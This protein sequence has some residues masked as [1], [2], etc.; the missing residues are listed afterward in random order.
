M[1]RLVGEAHEHCLSV[2]FARCNFGHEC[3]GDSGTGV[4]FFKE[5]D[6]LF[7]FG[8]KVV[9]ITFEK[10]KDGLCMYIIEHYTPS[11]VMLPSMTLQLVARPKSGLLLSPQHLRMMTPDYFSAI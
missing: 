7:V 2:R 11:S 3:S 6:K 9:L 8:W 10:L 5:A 1:T 4:S